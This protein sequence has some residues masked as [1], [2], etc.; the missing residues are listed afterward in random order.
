MPAKPGR[1]PRCKTSPRCR[2][3]RRSAWSPV[4]LHGA[5]PTVPNQRRSGSSRG[6]P[7]IAALGQEKFDQRI[8]RWLP[9]IANPRTRHVEF[10]P[11][12]MQPD[13]NQLI[14]DEHIEILKG[15]A[16]LCAL[17]KCEHVAR[18]LADAT[19]A[20]FK[21]IPNHGP[22]NAKLGNACLIALSSMECE[23]AAATTWPGR[24]ADQATDRPKAGRQSIENSRRRSGQTP[25][26]MAEL[27]VP[28]YGL[29]ASGSLTQTLGDFTAHLRITGTTTNELTWHRAADSKPQKSIPADVKRDKPEELKAL[30]RTAKDLTKMLPAQRD[31]VERLMTQAREWPYKT[32][33]QRYI[34]HPLLARDLSPSDLAHHRRRATR[35]ARGLARWK[36]CRCE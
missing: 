10:Q 32:W 7:F 14:S 4:L 9:L 5:Q 31:R 36:T 29:D 21:K 17:S 19:L 30:Q 6:A 18:A 12:F 1:M 27:A 22:R 2:N 34:E 28:T 16:W 3:R 13:P 35:H 26:D 15:L 33:R 25:E 23:E 20:A 8:V 11:G 24:C